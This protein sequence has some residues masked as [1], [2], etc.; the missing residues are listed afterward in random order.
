M[1]TEN[2]HKPN[3]FTPVVAAL[4]HLEYV[5]LI[6]DNP[7]NFPDCARTEIKL[8]DKSTAV[9]A[10]YHADTP[11]SNVRK[12]AHDIYQNVFIANSINLKRQPFRARERL[13]RQEKAIALCDEMLAEIYV[14]RR[15]FHLSTKRIKYWGKMV[16]EIKRSTEGW[17]ESDKDRF[18]ELLT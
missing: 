4:N 5:L 2:Q 11:T 15:H 7:K 13:A 9:L 6:T 3:E 18:R 14:C 17:H 1:A 8:G 10:V 16:V 12:Y